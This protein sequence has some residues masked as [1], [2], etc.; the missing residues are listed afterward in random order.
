M[1]LYK[2]ETV[3]QE[4]L[5]KATHKLEECMKVGNWDEEVFKAMSQSL[6]NLKDISKMRYNKERTEV[7]NYKMGRIASDKPTEG[8]TEFERLVYKVV[9]EKPVQD[10]MN[11]LTRVISEYLEDTRIMHPRAYENIMLKIKDILA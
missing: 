1:D 8:E 10:V 11:A 7:N 9:D 2:A 3:N 6:D 4:I 5:E